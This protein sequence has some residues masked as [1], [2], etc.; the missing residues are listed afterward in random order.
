MALPELRELATSLQVQGLPAAV[1]RP[2]LVGQILR[3]Y[4]FTVY[5]MDRLQLLAEQQPETLEHIARAK[6]LPVGAAKGLLVQ[7]IGEAQERM[8]EELKQVKSADQLKAMSEEDLLFIFDGLCGSTYHACAPA[9]PSIAPGKAWLVE[10][11]VQKYS[12]T[13]YPLNDLNWLAVNDL[14]ALRNIAQAKQI[15]N[16][17]SPM[18]TGDM[19]AEQIAAKQRGQIP[20]TFLQTQ[21][22]WAF[23][24]ARRLF[25]PADSETHSWDETCETACSRRCGTQPRPDEQRAVSDYLDDLYPA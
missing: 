1:T 3:T 13:A 20:A 22:Q 8:A 25:Q 24:K 16:S 4:R 7:Q 23:S 18:L 19:L 10:A 12:N 5:G 11:I 21:L 9:K 15:P 2:Q 6:G 17:H 14:D